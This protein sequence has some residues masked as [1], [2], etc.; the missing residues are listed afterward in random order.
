[1]TIV[2]AIDRYVTMVP[3]QELFP[4]MRENLAYK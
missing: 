2:A 4:D 1:M 3:L